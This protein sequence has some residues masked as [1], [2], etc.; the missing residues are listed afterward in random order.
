MSRT[1]Q[2]FGASV[3]PKL[4]SG[5]LISD[6]MMQREKKNKGKNTRAGISWYI[7][8][9][10]IWHDSSLRSLSL[11]LVGGGNVQCFQVNLVLLYMLRRATK[12]CSAREAPVCKF[13]AHAIWA[14]WPKTIGRRCNVTRRLTDRQT[15]TA[16]TID[17]NA[18][19]THTHME[20][21]WAPLNLKGQA[22][23]GQEA[24]ARQPLGGGQLLALMLDSTPT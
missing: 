6:A 16:P 14:E 15:D 9:D 22:R 11:W 3:D 20:F 21:E 23:P 4:V 12:T 13:M 24:A 1:V 18:H 2:I 5:G 7:N 8:Y 10:L 17:K 19:H